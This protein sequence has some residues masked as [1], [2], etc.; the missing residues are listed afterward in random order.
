MYSTIFILIK[1]PAEKEK[2]HM[3]CIIFN[4]ENK[5]PPYILD[6]FMAKGRV[7]EVDEIFLFIQT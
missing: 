5:R 2:Y 6:D 7:L 3:T 4:K 1:K